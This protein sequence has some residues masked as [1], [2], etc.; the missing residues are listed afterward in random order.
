MPQNPKL[1]G[2]A[3]PDKS[4]C[5]QYSDP[6]LWSKKPGGHALLF[7]PCHKL[8]LDDV[9]ARWISHPMKEMY[10]T[11]K[12]LFAINHNTAYY[13]GTYKC[14]P[15]S[16]EMIPGGCN[17]LSGLDLEA[18]ARVTISDNGASHKLYQDS[19]QT[20]M[21]L[22]KSDILKAECIGLQYIGFNENLYNM[23]VPMGRK[24]QG[25]EAFGNTRSG[26]EVPGNS[27]SKR[28]TLIGHD[29]DIRISEH[30]GNDEHRAK[31]QR[32]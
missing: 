4:I 15:L 24:L 22:W 16:C 21:D 3:S 30:S 11:T 32:K 31:R 28:R 14:L 13:E 12:E 6:F 18:L 20:V 25:D 23:L 8:Q 5:L 27:H 26:V 7:A 2:V 17:D 19:F 10:G 1:Q 29:D 9:E